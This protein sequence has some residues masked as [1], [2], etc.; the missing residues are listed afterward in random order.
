M[1]NL[2]VCL[3]LLALTGCATTGEPVTAQVRRE[4]AQIGI[5]DGKALLIPREDAYKYM[6]ADGMPMQCNGGNRIS[7]LCQCLSGRNR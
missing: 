2:I 1:K 3:G 6:C 5:E 4:Y 7:L